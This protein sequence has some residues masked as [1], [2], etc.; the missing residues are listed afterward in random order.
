MRRN[1]WDLETTDDRSAFKA[2]RD[3][4]PVSAALVIVVDARE[5]RYHLRCLEDLHEMLKA[6]GGWVP[7]GAAEE[8]EQPA[9]GSVEEWARSPKNPVGGWYGLTKGFRG[10]FAKY[11]PPIM[12]ALNLA[13]LEESTT[14]GRIRAI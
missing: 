14:G 1:P 5:R 9:A 8:R 10:G 11:V 4:T 3:I 12:A 13:E 7:L 2:F 6:E